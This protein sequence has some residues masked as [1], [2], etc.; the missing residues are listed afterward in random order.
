MASSSSSP[1]RAAAIAEADRR[2][3]GL[4]SVEPDAP[5]AAYVVALHLLGPGKK[6]RLAAEPEQT[7]QGRLEP[8]APVDQQIEAFLDHRNESQAVSS[9]QRAQPEGGIGLAFGYGQCGV[10]LAP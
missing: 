7:L 4:S 10:G 6:W 8:G 3:K 1:T 9:R 5:E 2:E